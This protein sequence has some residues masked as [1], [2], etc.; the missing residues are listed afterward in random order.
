MP[1]SNVKTP[2]SSKSDVDRQ[3]DKLTTVNLSHM[4]AESHAL[5]NRFLKICKVLTGYLESYI[6]EMTKKIG[7]LACV[8]IIPAKKGNINQCS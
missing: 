2:P 3:T 6:K 4:R 1:I 7:L 5:Y 8:F